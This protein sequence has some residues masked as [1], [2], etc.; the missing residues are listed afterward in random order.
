MTWSPRLAL[1]VL[2]RFLSS[3]HRDAIAG[4]LVERYEDGASSWWVWWQVAGAIAVDTFTQLRA[5][6]I[7]IVGA[8][9]VGWTAMAAYVRVVAMALAWLHWPPSD[10]RFILLMAPTPGYVAGGWIAGR[11]AGLPAVWICFVLMCGQ[12]AVSLAGF[13]TSFARSP[14]PK[15]FLD[16]FILAIFL[17]TA[18]FMQWTLVHLLSS[19]LAGS[20]RRDRRERP[21][22]TSV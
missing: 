3:R 17:G 6:P 15:S 12:V 10:P 2:D 16:L 18:L 13:V 7:Q 20:R 8:A 1:W 4:D 19:G 21:R 22:P 5:H 9:C 11:L 14:Q